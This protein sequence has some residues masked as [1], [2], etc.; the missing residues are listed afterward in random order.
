MSAIATARG[1][2]PVSNERNGAENIGSALADAARRSSAALAV[3][4]ATRMVIGR[5]LAARRDSRG[6]AL[7]GIP[8]SLMGVLNT[9]LLLA[10]GAYPWGM[11][12]LTLGAARW[13]RPVSSGQT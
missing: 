10:I 11:R 3:T 9:R 2:S 4:H 1:A 6:H 7:C 8:R 12:G 13:A 5:S